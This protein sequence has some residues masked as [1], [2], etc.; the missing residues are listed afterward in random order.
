MGCSTPCSGAADRGREHID[1]RAWSGVCGCHRDG[2]R[3][4]NLVR[5]RRH[6]RHVWRHVVGQ[7]RCAQLQQ[8]P[9]A[10][11]DANPR[12]CRLGLDDHF[13]VTVIGGRHSGVVDG[14]VHLHRI[15]NREQVRGRLDEEGGGDLQ[16][17]RRA[18]IHSYRGIEQNA[19]LIGDLFDVHDRDVGERRLGTRPVALG[20]EDVVAGTHP[21]PS[22]SRSRRPA[23]H[24]RRQTSSTRGRTGRK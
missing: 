3:T 7:G 18:E 22:P 5:R 21:A 6:D 24:R 19:R 4:E 2:H 8:K 11:A 9:R 15:G 20:R 1:A 16:P 13:V 14:D 17:E 10:A 23:R 12:A